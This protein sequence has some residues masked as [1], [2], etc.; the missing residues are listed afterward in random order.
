MIDTGA[1]IGDQTQI[2]PGLG[3]QPCIDAVG[4]RRH[5]NISGLHRFGQFRFRHRRVVQVQC[6]VEQLHHP[7]FD[8]IRQLAGDDDF[9]LVFGHE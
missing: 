2:I 8:N 5:Q 7:G 3:Q 1:V 4:Q 9:G 6:D